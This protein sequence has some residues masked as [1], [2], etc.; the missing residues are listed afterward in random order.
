MSKPRKKPHEQTMWVIKNISDPD[1]AY[2]FNGYMEYTK[3]RCL[4]TFVHGTGATW[5]D[6]RK[7]GYRCVKVKV[8]EIVK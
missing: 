4:R 7:E 3:R 2:F 5:D 1:A 6:Y 8:T